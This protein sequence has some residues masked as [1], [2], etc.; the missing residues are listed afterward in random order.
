MADNADG[1]VRIATTI[2]TENLQKQLDQVK[3]KLDKTG[4]DI[5]KK[6]GSFKK[7]G[8]FIKSGGVSA[9]VGGTA[10]AIAIKKTVD[11][12]ND[13][14]AA[15]KVQ[16][17]AEAALQIAAKNN[18]YLNEESVYNL[19]QFAGELQNMSEYGDEL[20]IKVMSQ[21]A[22]TGRTEEEIR[23][24]MTAAA[25]MAA[26][27][28]QDLASAAQQLNATLNGNAGT[29]GRQIAGISNLTEE[30]LKNG[31]AIELVAKQYKGSAAATADVGVQLNNTWGDFKENIGRG[32]ENVTQ[33]VKKFFLD[34]L[35]DINEATAKTNA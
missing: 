31:K 14:A 10:A 17:K 29:L 8:D 23:Q 33:P 9:A 19:K 30:E 22:A 20:S 18:P 4:K 2:D 34:V 24:I 3:S 13:C 16:E 25:D 6:G 12:L 26:V 27:T 11:A 32:W 5:E 35:N 15:Y 21:L 7:L 28:G 1:E